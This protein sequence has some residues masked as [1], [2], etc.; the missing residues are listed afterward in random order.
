MPIIS[1]GVDFG[2]LGSCFSWSNGYVHAISFSSSKHERRLCLLELSLSFLEK[3]SLPEIRFR[4]FAKFP[5]PMKRESNILFQDFLRYKLLASSK[6][7]IIGS[8]KVSGNT[9]TT[10]PASNAVPPKMKPGSQLT[11][12]WSAKNRG[13]QNPPTLL[14]ML[15][16]PTAM[17]LTGVGNSS[18]V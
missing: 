18:A 9:I 7:I 1:R 3:M 8:F 4:H 5:V 10:Q 2:I 16:V 6:F 17:L 11:C 14:I 12:S 13:L 15:H